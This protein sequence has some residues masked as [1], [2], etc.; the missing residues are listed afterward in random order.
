[1]EAPILHMKLTSFI[2]VLWA[3]LLLASLHGLIAGTSP[4]GSL[5]AS[6][7]PVLSNGAGVSGHTFELAKR[8][9]GKPT[10]KKPRKSRKK[11]VQNG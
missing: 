4:A 6:P 11:S 1:M 9:N 5:T 3:V 8:S 10:T 2:L 7:R